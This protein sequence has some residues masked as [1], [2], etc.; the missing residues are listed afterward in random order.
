MFKTLW[1]KKRQLDN[2]ISVANWIKDLKSE[3]IDKE[4]RVHIIVNSDFH[5][6]KLYVYYN[7]LTDDE[8]KDILNN[9]LDDMKDKINK[10]TQEILNSKHN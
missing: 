7:C 5:I 4:W 8:L 1:E 2:L 6:E 3:Y 9:L 10:K